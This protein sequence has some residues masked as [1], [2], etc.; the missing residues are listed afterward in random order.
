MSK[1]AQ[2]LLITF[3]LATASVLYELVLAQ[4]LS[5]VMGN[6]T[7]RYNLTIGLYIASMGVGAYLVDKFSS[8]HQAE[9]F[10]K[11]E[12]SLSMLGILA[13]W[14]VIVN[15]YFL[16]QMANMNVI[17]YYNLLPQLYSGFFNNGLIVL[18]GVLSG[19][20]LPLLIRIGKTENVESSMTVLSLDYVGTMVGAAIFPLLLFPNFNLFQIGYMVGLINILVAVF[21]SFKFKQHISLKIYGLIFLIIICV[22]LFG[23]FNDELVR[24]FYY[25]K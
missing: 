1:K 13:P 7:Y 21:L 12:F 14:L 19:I 11:V 20:E 18:I 24:V 10:L 2:W 5:T 16:Q 6:T 4:T 9:Y 22:F 17:N 15:D 23:N 25:A 3:L 8:L